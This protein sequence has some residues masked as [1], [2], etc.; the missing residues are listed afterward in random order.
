MSWLP[1]VWAVYLL[2]IQFDVWWEVYGLVSVEKWTAVA[3][4]LLLA[5]ALQLFAA[6]GLVLP[7]HLENYPEDL[8]RY[9]QEDGRWAV[10]VVG[11]F[12]ATS[13]VANTA[14]FDVDVLGFMNIWNTLGVVICAAVVVSKR[15]LVQGVATA[16][17]G[18][19]LGA[20]IWI[21]VPSTY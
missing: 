1:L 16:V 19:W 7:T 9:F 20:Y 3:F 17:F 21:F 4:L 5:I 2:V 15:R 11:L 8:D 6:G 10:A 14:L 18:V 12:Q 13:M